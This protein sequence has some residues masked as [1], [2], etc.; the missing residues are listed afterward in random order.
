VPIVADART[1]VTAISSNP[2]DKRPE[3]IA[4][5]F[6][7]IAARYDFLNHLLSG[8]L[9]WYWR[10]RAIR[11]LRLQRRDV[12]L[13][14]CTGTCDLA[15]QAI[16]SGAT[17]VVGID[18]AGEMLRIGQRKLAK[19]HLERRVTLV[20]ADA[21]QIPIAD[22]AADA[23]TIA[24]GI[25]NVQDPEVACREMVRVLKPGGRLAVLEFSIPRVPVLRHAYVWYFRHVLPRIGRLISRHGDAYDYLP[26]SVGAFSGPREFAGVLAAAGFADVRTVRLTFG[27]VYLYLGSR[28]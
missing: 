8:G 14:L 24:F 25:R 22:C 10:W 3:K 19:R 1:A 11:A 21:M 2:P 20:R 6:D 16:R 28:R 15:V 4:G 9:D 7:A 12:I 13:D 5:M 26:T 18:F 17:R 23:I 27:V